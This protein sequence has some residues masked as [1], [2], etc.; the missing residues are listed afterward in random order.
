VQAS[1]QSEQLELVPNWVSQPSP[2]LP[3]QL[4]QPE[5]QAPIWHAP[6]TQLPLAWLY[7]QLSP[8]PLQFCTVPSWVS[9]P[10]GTLPSQSPQP[11]LQS[12]IWQTPKAQVIWAPPPVQ[13]TPQ[14][15]QSV[16][17]S[18]E[19][20]Q[21]SESVPLQLSYSGLQ[22]SMW[23]TS[24]EQEAVAW[25]REQAVPQLPQFCR[26]SR[27]SSQPFA[28]FPSQLPHPESQAPI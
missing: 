17:V 4:P 13:G 16:S 12:A 26:E 27:E 8:H 22:E 20:S 6:A 21:P 3:L 18:R 24:P 15:P 19:V 10:L 28:S 5:S 14:A 23:Q 1:P 2:V 7:V 9:Q 25:A 11:G